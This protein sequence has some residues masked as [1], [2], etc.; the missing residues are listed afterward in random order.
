MRALTVLRQPQQNTIKDAFKVRK[1]IIIPAPH[2]MKSFCLQESC[3]FFIVAQLGFRAMGSAIHFHNQLAFPASK[4]RHIGA[5]G[6]LTHKFESRQPAISDGLP[7]TPLGL[8]IVPAQVTRAVQRCW[9]LKGHQ[10]I[11][12]G[13]RA[14]SR[15]LIRPSAPS[16]ILL[17]FATQD[18][19]RRKL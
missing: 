7:E 8:S 17:R 10:Q 1:H 18:G 15:A 12:P 5:N 11:R 9:S 3:S 2:Y 6:K 16:P 4:V 19:R 13:L 14:E